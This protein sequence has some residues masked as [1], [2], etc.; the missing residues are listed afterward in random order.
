MPQSTRELKRET[1]PRSLLEFFVIYQADNPVA[2]EVTRMT[3]IGSPV[4]A[5]Y[6]MVAR[7]RNAIVA[8]LVSIVWLDLNAWVTSA[9]VCATLVV[10]IV[11]RPS[12]DYPVGVLVTDRRVVTAQMRARG[13]APIATEHPAGAVTSATV[14]RNL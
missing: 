5:Y 4:G 1:M 14:M 13:Q 10:S 11:I 7:F 6:R 2:D 12:R 8:L 9:I 3:F